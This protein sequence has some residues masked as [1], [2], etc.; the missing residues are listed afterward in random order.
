M[1]LTL[2]VDWDFYSIVTRY[3]QTACPVMTKKEFPH[4]EFIEKEGLIR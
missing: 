4:N 1:T 3:G 2:K